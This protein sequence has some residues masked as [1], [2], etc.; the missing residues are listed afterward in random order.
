[1]SNSVHHFYEFGP[2]RL[3]VANRLLLREGETL[4][5]TP[6]AVETL[7][8]L[9]EHGGEVI[10]KDDLMKLVWPDHVVEEG[11]LTQ[12]IYLLRK[13]LSNGSDGQKYIET[14]PRRGYR[15]VGEVRATQDEGNGNAEKRRLDKNGSLTSSSFH[16]SAPASLD[17]VSP[18]AKRSEA[19]SLPRRRRLNILILTCAAALITSATLFYLAISG[20]QKTTEALALKLNSAGQKPPTEQPNGNTEAYQ[21]YLKGRYYWNKQTAPAL[22]EAIKYFEQAL[23]YDPDYAPAYAGLADAYSVLGSHYDTL[24]QSQSD[25]MPK[26]KEAALHALK[27][28]DLSAEAHTALGVVKQRYDWDWSGAEREFKRA[29]ELNPNYAYAHQAYAL[30]LAGMGQLDTAKTEIKRALELDPQ[31]LSINRDLGRI[32]YFAREYDQAIEQFRRALK[33]DSFEPLA[34]PLRRLLAWTYLAQGRHEQ[35]LTE[36]IEILQLQKTSPERIDAL[37][38]AYNAAGMR[39]Y[40]HKW[41]ELQSERIRRGQLSPFYVAQVYAFL[42]EKDQA[43]AYLQKAYTDRSLG[44][45]ALHYDSVFDN[46]RADSRYTSLIQ[47]IGLT[48]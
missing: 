26:A 5:L 39:G 29:I 23:S 48:P 15:F 45:A 32:F 16:H 14:I 17:T 35:A 19:S 41:L 36:F 12:N 44:L 46:L 21:A 8:A 22:E 4:P 31:S 28:N 7:L 20:R 13:A 3:D 40:W 47:H 25:A 33:I 18:D 38:Q 6:K 43:F 24:E 2:Y 37:R 34:I 9:I 1:M 27:L 30:H 11:N 42:D 10:R